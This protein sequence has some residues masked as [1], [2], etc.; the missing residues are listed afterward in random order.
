M[1]WVWEHM[2]GRGERS[3]NLCGGLT[4][5]LGGMGYGETVRLE[6]K[7]G[8]RLPIQAV[9]EFLWKQDH[10]ESGDLYRYAERDMKF[11]GS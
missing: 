2:D 8:S 10:V 9:P 6:D 11:G 3:I 1:D 4:S 5:N 7:R